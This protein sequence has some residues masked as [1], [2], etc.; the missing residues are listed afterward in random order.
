VREP[1]LRLKRGPLFGE[2][3]HDDLPA[4]RGEVARE[5]YDWVRAIPKGKVMTYGQI[6]V[7]MH[8][9]I[10]AR[11]VGWILHN[12]PEDVPWQRVVNASGGCSTRRLPEFPLDL[13]QRLLEGEGVRFDGEGTLELPRYRYLPAVESS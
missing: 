13:Q 10:S 5:V 1:L 6:S 4:E 9:R 3:V 2:K 12:A 7:L 11:A 8:Q